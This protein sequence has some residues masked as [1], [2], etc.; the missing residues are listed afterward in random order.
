[1]QIAHGKCSPEGDWCHLTTRDRTGLTRIFNEA[2]ASARVQI[3]CRTYFPVF[4][5]LDFHH[6]GLE[7]HVY[8][9]A[10]GLGL[11]DHQ[12]PDYGAARTE[13]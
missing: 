9:N 6:G 12:A 2:T 7:V 3:R 4:W 13:Q 1:M 5:V 11:V 8:L 10:K